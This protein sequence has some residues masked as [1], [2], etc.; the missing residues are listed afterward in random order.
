MM[1][2]M[3][4]KRCR[5]ELRAVAA[6][7]LLFAVTWAPPPA[8]A[9]PSIELQ[10]GHA[11]GEPGDSVEIP[12][13]IRIP[14]FVGS[15]VPVAGI[16]IDIEA[17]APL[18]IPIT[19]SQRPDCWRNTALTKD[20]TVYSFPYRL[21]DGIWN[22]MRALVLSVTNVDTIPDGSWLFTCRFGIAADAAP[23]EYQLHA[24]RLMGSTPWG[25]AIA[26]TS[27]GGT[28]LV[29]DPA[30]G[31]APLDSEGSGAVGATSASG[32]CAIDRRESSRAGWLLLPLLPLILWRRAFS[33]GAMR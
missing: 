4:T 15:P 24:T 21:T 33:R 6:G 16:Q 23:G 1:S 2:A 27:S 18:T 11:S 12:V 25:D 29:A 31:T 10:L 8:T 9:Y 19:A 5:T 13:S 28:I 14:D 17:E 26:A 32:G 22:V 3:L 7:L 30:Q 20:Y